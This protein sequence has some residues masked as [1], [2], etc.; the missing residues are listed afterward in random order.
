MIPVDFSG[1]GNRTVALVQGRGGDSPRPRIFSDVIWG[2][3]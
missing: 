2:A 1:T 3:G